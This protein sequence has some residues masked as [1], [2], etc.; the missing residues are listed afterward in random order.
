MI[1]KISFLIFCVLLITSSGSEES[2]EEQLI[3]TWTGNL[4]QVDCCT[5]DIEVTITSLAIGQNIASGRFFNCNAEICNNDLF[6][7]DEIRNN[8]LACSFSWRLDALLD[9][10]L[11]VF[12]EA[13]GDCASGTVT[14]TLQE[15]GA[16]QYLFVDIDNPD[17]R[18]SGE[19]TKS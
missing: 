8:P 16:L 17:N 13:S 5:F 2:F 15:N 12:E 1:N 6:F 7:C 14:V 4:L 19:L 3:G 9:P 11:T 10:S 18:T